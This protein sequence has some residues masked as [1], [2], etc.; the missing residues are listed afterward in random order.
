MVIQ[1]HQTKVCIQIVPIE[2]RSLIC[3]IGLFNTYIH[4]YT[5]LIIIPDQG[6]NKGSQAKNNKD[7]EK[8]K[9]K[10]KDM[11]K[12]QEEKRKQVKSLIDKIP[13]QKESLF[14]YKLDYSQVNARAGL[15]GNSKRGQGSKTVDRAIHLLCKA[16]SSNHLHRDFYKVILPCPHLLS[17]A[18]LAFTYQ[19]LFWVVKV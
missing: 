5:I 10:E 7:K 18:K 19:C 1:Y 8:E 2:K 6:S 16:L 3:T 17:P 9:E 12:T 4:I 11:A 13:T 14:A 15:N